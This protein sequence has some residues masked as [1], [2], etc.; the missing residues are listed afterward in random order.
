MGAGKSTIGKRLA[1]KLNYRF[2]DCDREIEN[3]TGARISLIFDIEGE[4]GFR[5]REKQLLEELTENTHTVLATGGGVILDEENRE[6]LSTRG[7][8]IY[9]EASIK[10]LRK[11][12]SKDKR[13]P[14]LN[15]EDPDSRMQEIFREREPLYKETA[16]AVVNTDKKPI[17]NIVEK[18]CQLIPAE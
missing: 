12:T 17:K 10:Q 9:L 3:R 6:L 11:R 13:R 1:K 14:L 18:I 5:K 15:T 16:D 4:A 2:I 7:M 8:V